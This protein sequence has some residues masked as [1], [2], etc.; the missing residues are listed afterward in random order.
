MSNYTTENRSFFKPKLPVDAAELSK[1]RERNNPES[2][3]VGHHTGRCVHCG[4]SDLWDDNLAYG[5]NGC[6]AMLGG[7]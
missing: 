5:C 2:K 1:L 3:P 6:G 7:N 4:S